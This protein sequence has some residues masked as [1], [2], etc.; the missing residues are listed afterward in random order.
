MITFIVIIIAYKDDIY[1]SIQLILEILNGQD[2]KNLTVSVKS[3]FVSTQTG[4][5]TII[6]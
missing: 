5:Q 2:D 1:N 4:G 6:I 3:I